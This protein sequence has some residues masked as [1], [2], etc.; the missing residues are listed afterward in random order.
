[1]KNLKISLTA[2]TL[3]LGVV[4]IS[5]AHGDNTTKNAN[6]NVEISTETVADQ[7]AVTGETTE[8]G[9]DYYV[10]QPPTGSELCPGGTYACLISSDTPPDAENRIPK[11]QATIDEFKASPFK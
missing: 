11:T 2:L 7:W 6:D 9:V 3:V 1:M 8:N 5:F 10:V 4:L